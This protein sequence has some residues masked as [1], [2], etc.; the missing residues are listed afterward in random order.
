MAWAGMEVVAEMVI[1]VGSGID[2]GALRSTL[3]SGPSPLSHV[4]LVRD[5]LRS[6]LHYHHPGSRCVWKESLTSTWIRHFQTLCWHRLRIFPISEV[7]GLK[8]AGTSFRFVR[9]RASSGG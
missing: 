4:Y 5:I 1:D 3:Y 8:W 7:G 2:L 9:R 6:L